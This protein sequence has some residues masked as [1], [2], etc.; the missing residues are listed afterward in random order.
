[1]TTEAPIVIDGF[2][3]RK[4]EPK[5]AEAIFRN[6]TQDPEVTRYLV[7]TPHRT[8]QD[9][10]EWIRHC[11]EAFDA[12]T[13]LTYVIA[14]AGTDEAVGMIGAKVTGHQ[15]VVG[16]VL[17]KRYWGRGIMTQ[18]LT[19]LGDELLSRPA[20]YRVYALHD[21]DNPASGRVME[22]AGM[23]YEGLLRRA[24]IHPNISDE[25]RDSKLYARTK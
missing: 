13:N 11:I 24:G 17:T 9:S 12:E 2:V 7:W 14:E 15:A 20:V 6:Y 3:L 1:M 22:K 18:A 5:D 16:Y 23:V 4:P 21:V 25:P 10:A 19:A 8:L